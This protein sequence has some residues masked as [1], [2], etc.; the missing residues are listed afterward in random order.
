MTEIHAHPVIHTNGIVNRMKQSFFFVALLSLFVVATDLHAQ[1]RDLR[2]E[3]L[4]LD[5]NGSDSTTNIVT[6]RASPTLLQNVI[7][8]IP[9]PG[10]GTAEFML[11]TGSGGL[12]SWRLGGNSGTIPGTDFLGTTDSTAL[13][14]Q[15]RGG[16]GTIANSLILNENGSLSQDS[17]GDERG[18]DA[19]DL[20]IARNAVTQVAAGPYGLIGGG[21]KNGIAPSADH[22]TIGGGWNN[23]IRDG[24]DYGTIGGGRDNTIDTNAQYVAISGG[25]QNTA[26]AGADYSTISGGRIHDIDS[27]TLHATIG[28]GSIN[29]VGSGSHNS[30]IGGGTGNTIGRGTDH[31]TIGGGGG[32]RI[33]NAARY[34]TI[35]GGDA[36][37]IYANTEY[38]TL[39]GGLFNYIRSGADYATIGGGRN[40]EVKPS[41]AYSMIGGGRSN[42]IH[43]SAE[44]A[45]IGGGRSN[46]VQADAD[47]ST[48][49]GGWANNIDGQSSV[50]PGGRGLTL[51][52]DRSFGFL[53]NAD[54]NDM[55]ISES[56]VAIFGNANLWLANNTGTPSQIRFYESN[57]TTG[58]FPSTDYYISF[59]APPLGD[60]IEYVLPASKPTQAGEVLKV[61]SVNG[62]IVTLTWGTDN[63]TAGRDGSDIPSAI[64]APDDGSDV[65]SRMR[66]LAAQLGAGEQLREAQMKWIETLDTEMQWLKQQGAVPTS[67]GIES[68][69]NVNV[70]SAE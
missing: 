63:T 17:A 53:A 32:N 65:E 24:A 35:S 9:D 18:A 23:A 12:N 25:Q 21:E 22:S 37:R 6:I 30:T 50:I 42:V 8:T 62:D 14:L 52:A 3:R 51:N 5:D 19:V 49:G 15:V 38:A 47:Y 13:Q 55:T 7:L 27:T 58:P 11:T 16:S 29:L 10:T 45:T 48:I 33:D 67:E 36:N 60:T 69:E 1:E 57:S 41:A 61:S 40:N 31:G 2:A 56:D 39:T 34:S 66:K 54:S 59:E 28:G 26:G 43:D 44:Y 64:A 68:K 4:V 46:N 70:Q 20:Q